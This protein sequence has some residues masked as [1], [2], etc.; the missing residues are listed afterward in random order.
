MMPKCE[1]DPTFPTNLTKRRAHC[2][3]SATQLILRSPRHCRATILGSGATVAI[4]G[5]T[6]ERVGDRVISVREIAPLSRSVAPLRLAAAPLSAVR[7]DITLRTPDRCG[8]LLRA[9]LEAPAS[10][11]SAYSYVRGVAV[12]WQI[13]GTHSGG[14]VAPDSGATPPPLITHSSATPRA[15]LFATP[16]PLSRHSAPLGRLAARRGAAPSVW[17]HHITRHFGCLKNGRRDGASHAPARQLTLS[18]RRANGVARRLKHTFAPA[19][20]T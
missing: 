3:W 19:A 20:L 16:A 2:V 14:T 15:T 17:A 8:R 12:Q 6:V 18:E 10:V 1:S 13:S 5:A 7:G 11:R 4:S 9:C